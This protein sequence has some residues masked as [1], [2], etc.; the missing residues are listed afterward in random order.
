MC[1]SLWIQVDNNNG[2]KLE[3]ARIVLL[4]GNKA[5]QPYYKQELRPIMIRTK[6]GLMRYQEV[7]IAYMIPKEVLCEFLK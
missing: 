6:L 7:R 5:I 4:Q 2:P 3:L 1:H